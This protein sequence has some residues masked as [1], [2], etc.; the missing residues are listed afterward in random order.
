MCTIMCKERGGKFYAPP[1]E[2]LVDNG[3]MIAWL[4]ILQ[5]EKKEGNIDIHPYERTDDVIMEWR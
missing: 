1:N 4:G 2:V 3:L 5:K